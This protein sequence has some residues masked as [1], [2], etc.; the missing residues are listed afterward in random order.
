MRLKALRQLDF[1]GVRIEKNAVFVASKEK[2][3]ELIAK[4]LAVE[5]KEDFR[6][7]KTK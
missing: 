6:D 1:S 4:N 2:G 3:K 7:I 5:T